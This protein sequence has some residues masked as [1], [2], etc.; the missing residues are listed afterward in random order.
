M[1]NII[2]I[3]ALISASSYFVMISVITLGWFLLRKK[4]LPS[5][6]LPNN[7][8]IIIPVKNEEANI[9]NCL[10]SINKQNFQ[11]T[12]YEVILVNDHSSDNS[13]Q[14]IQNYLKENKFDNIHF[15]NQN[16]ENHGKKEAIKK[17]IENAKGELIITSDAD[18]SMGSNWLKTISSYFSKNDVSMVLGPVCIIPGKNIFS[19]IQSLEF[20][21]LMGITGGAAS[22]KTPILANG[23]NLAFR[24][25]LF[26]EAGDYTI[27][28]ELKSGDDIFF[29][30]QVKKMKDKKIVFAK[31]FEATVFTY[32]Q[33][34]L[35]SFFNQRLRWAGKTG[36]YKDYLAIAAAINVFL[37]NFL[38]VACIIL[39]VFQ[40]SYFVF[41]FLFLAIVKFII[42]L[43]IISGVSYFFKKSH[44]LYYYP[45]V[46]I[47]YPWYV[48]IT[49][50]GSLFSKTNW[51]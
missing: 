39:S 10:N 28:K 49:A 45:I 36:H 23:A 32:P 8:S 42:D 19:K 20:M 33:K 38:I 26:S 51:K 24:K 47:L 5:E 18:C 31:N 37:I 27:G 34:S 21:S 1:E 50:I 4:K 41:P 29:L 30:Q 43:P 40:Q 35:K 16:K 44:L 14:L 11:K 6:V 9:L 46:F 15:I 13:M 7:I 48:C 25:T 22:V 2:R 3:I 12:H 17:G